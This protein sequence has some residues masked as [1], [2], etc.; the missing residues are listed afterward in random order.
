MSSNPCL[1]CTISQDCCHEMQGLMV[2]RAEYD[3]AFRPHESALEVTHQGPLLRLTAKHGPC[4]NWQGACTCYE[5]RPMECRLF[6]Y[7]VSIVATS[8]RAVHVTVHDRVNCP[9]KSELRPA[10]EAARR[11]IEP[12]ALEAY[13]NDRPVSIHFEDSGWGR[14]KALLFRIG[15]RIRW[16]KQ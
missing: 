14:L 3:R 7:T 11:L 4:P 16:F 10:K 15:L 8:P 2:T 5:D 12:F 13:G 6:P 1:A 9:L